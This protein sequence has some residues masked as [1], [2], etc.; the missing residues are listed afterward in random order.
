MTTKFLRL[1]T[2]RTLAVA[3]PAAFLAGA[4]RV[5]ADIPA[6]ENL[7]PSDTLS[8]FTVPDCSVF[9]TSAKVS[10]QMQFWNDPAIKPFHDKF[11]SKLTEKY[12]APLEK[13]LGLKVDD[14]ADLPQGQL[15]LA[16]TANGSD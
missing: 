10:P 7:L 5:R 13:D 3:F 14:F 16:L 6:A 1:V 4:G 9:R 11:M 2:V 15:T 8:F 12:I